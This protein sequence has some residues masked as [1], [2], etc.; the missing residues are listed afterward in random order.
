[1]LKPRDRIGGRMVTEAEFID[2]KDMTKRVGLFE[3][4]NVGDYYMWSNK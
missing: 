4:D 1:M 3:M 2:M